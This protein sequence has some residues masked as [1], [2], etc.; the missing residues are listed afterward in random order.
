[1]PIVTDNDIADA[2]PITNL[3]I[4]LWRNRI[5][6][7]RVS[8]DSQDPD[9]PVTNVVNTSLALKW[10]QDVTGSPLAMPDYITFNIAGLGEIN[11]IGIAGHNLGSINATI[12]VE[13]FGS[14][15]PFHQDSPPVAEYVTG[16]SPDDDAPLLFLFAGVQTSNSTDLLRIR[17]EHGA[18]TGNAQEAAE[19]AVIYV[20][21]VLV[22][23]EGIQAD[24]TPLNLARVTNVRNGEAEDGTFLG[25]IIVGE[26]VE[27]TARFANLSIDWTRDNLLDFLAS[28]DEFPFFYAWQ[29]EDYPEEVAFAWLTEQ[30]QP[31][32][33]IDGF[34]SIDLPMRGLIE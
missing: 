14:A 31:V 22:M 34:F 6:A 5:S 4:I 9:F 25:R 21:K 18:T 2:L 27:S 23:E 30:P 12:A 10:K 26:W 28:A 1:M 24:H 32:L 8:T 33:D 29:P 17:I 7:A 15:S 11:A 16:Y 3:P 20:G 19:I 13:G